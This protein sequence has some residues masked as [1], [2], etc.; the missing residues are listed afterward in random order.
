MIYFLKL[1]SPFWAPAP[2]ESRKSLALPIFSPSRGIRF[3][4]E[5]TP[6]RGYLG[7]CGYFLNSLYSRTDNIEDEAGVRR[8]EFAIRGSGRITGG[9]VLGSGGN[10][11]PIGVKVDLL[12]LDLLAERPT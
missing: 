8:L 7:R 10:R 4:S 2:P 12:I 11:R 5:E 3:V 9:N 1:E 6:P